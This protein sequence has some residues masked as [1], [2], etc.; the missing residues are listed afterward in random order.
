[1]TWENI[2]FLMF[3]CNKLDEIYFS[4]NHKKYLYIYIYIY[5]Y[6]LIEI[7]SFFIELFH[8]RYNNINITYSD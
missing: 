7:K 2:F 6:I 1:M 8:N 5:I 3:T 4:I